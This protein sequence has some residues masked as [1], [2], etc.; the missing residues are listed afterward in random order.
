MNTIIPL[1]VIFGKDQEEII[2]NVLKEMGSE[3]IGTIEKTSMLT[4]HI[5]YGINFKNAYSIYF[6]GAQTQLQ[7]M[8]QFTKP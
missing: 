3:R 4:S 1:T 8:K 6:F 7:L 2:D 5:T